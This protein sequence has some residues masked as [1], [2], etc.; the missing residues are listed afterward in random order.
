LSWASFNQKYFEKSLENDELKNEDLH[1]ST[2]KNIRNIRNA[3]STDNANKKNG[4]K[5]RK[6]LTSL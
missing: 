5:G 4:R 1:Q 6:S 2:I 3:N